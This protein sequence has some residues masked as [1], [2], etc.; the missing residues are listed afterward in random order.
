MSAILGKD[1][2]NLGRPYTHTKVLFGEQG[3]WVEE[4]SAM[5]PYGLVLTML[6]E[7]PADEYIDALSGFEKAAESKEKEKMVEAFYRL[8]QQFMRLPFYNFYVRD[9]GALE[10]VIIMLM[11]EGRKELELADILLEDDGT[12]LN[13]YVWAR[14]DLTMIQ[15]RYS[16]FLETLYQDV[17]FEKRKGQR[18]APLAGMIVR[19]NMEAYVSGVSLGKSREVDAPPV[20]VQ[21][22]ILQREGQKPEI[23]EKIYFDRLVD[24]VYVELMKGMQKGFVPKKCANCGKWFLQRPGMTYSYCARKLED[25]RTCRDVGANVSFQDKVRNNEIWKLHQRAYKKYFAR[26]RKGTMSKSEFEKWSRE[27]EQ[28]RNEALVRYGDAKTEEEKREIEREIR[29]KLN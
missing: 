10:P 13:K 22:E 14:E 28:L 3:Y 29:D 19:K 17:A 12:I 15:E 25:G 18:K 8:M 11:I 4:N 9:F 24:F 5:C 6:L 7:Y 2:L 1:L 26:T 21:F 16:W 27:A 20:N 23:V